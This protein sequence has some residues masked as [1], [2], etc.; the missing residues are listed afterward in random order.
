[1]LLLPELDSLSDG[2]GVCGDDEL[3]AGVEGIGEG[4]EE[5]GGEVIMG[6]RVECSADVKRRL[7]QSSWSSEQS[8]RWR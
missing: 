6:M 2:G 5:G 7:R 8:R 4:E 1:M 3:E